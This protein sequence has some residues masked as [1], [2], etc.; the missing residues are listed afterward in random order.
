MGILD[1]ILGFISGSSRSNIN[2]AGRLATKAA[3]HSAYEA[4][5]AAFQADALAH[6]DRTIS[7]EF[8]VLPVTLAE[9]TAS[10]YND[11]RTPMNTAVLFVVALNVYNRDRDESIAMINYLRGPNPLNSDDISF[12]DGHMAQN[13][14]DGYL[15]RSYLS[16]AV[17]QNGYTPSQP[18]TIATTDNPYT[19]YDRGDATVFVH[20]GGDSGPR[21]ITMRKSA[22]SL[23]HL[24]TLSLLDSVQSP[25]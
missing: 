6:G 11:L 20:C 13:N 1:T 8:S 3:R 15:S 17:P 22:D 4:D 5:R 7:A 9:L 23:W 16:G 19:Y 18:Y 12:L 21:S 14:K 24:G 2:R 25:V 10:P